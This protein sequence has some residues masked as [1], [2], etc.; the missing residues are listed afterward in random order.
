[1]E[2]QE[3]MLS[4][5]GKG[6]DFGFKHGNHGSIGKRGTIFNKAGGK[7][8]KTSQTALEC[9]VDIRSHKVLQA[10]VFIDVGIEACADVGGKH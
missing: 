2:R 9:L 6:G 5:D 4:S 10:P 8:E 3:G 1:M 7:K